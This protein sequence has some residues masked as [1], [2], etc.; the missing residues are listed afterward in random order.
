[1][2]TKSIISNEKGSIY[3]HWDGYPT[4]VG[5]MLLEHYQDADKVNRLIALGNI[6]YLEKEVETEK[7]HSF[8]CPAKGVTVAY[9]RD[10]GEEF[11]TGEGWSGDFAYHFED[12]VWY[13]LD[14]DK[15]RFDLKEVLEDY[16]DED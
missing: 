2:S 1:M 15:N 8:D 4:G 3:C 6:S 11:S 16:E 7:E 13:I 12:G 10:R 14:S 5:K 9:H